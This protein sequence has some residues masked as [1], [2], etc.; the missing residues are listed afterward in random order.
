MEAEKVF[1]DYLKQYDWNDNK[2]HLKIVHTFGVVKAA[3]KIAEGIRM[4]EEDRKLAELIALLHDIGRFEQLKRYHTFDDSV[5]P[6]AQ[7]SI[8]ILFREGMIRKFIPDRSLDSVIYNAIRLHG[9]YR[10]EDSMYRRYA[11][12]EKKGEGWEERL[13]RETDPEVLKRMILH[14]KLIR[15]A[16]KVDNFRVKSEEAVET[17]VDV[18]AKEL[19]REEITPFI[20]DT[21]LKHEPILNADRKTHM[22]MWVSY[23]GY[24]YDLNFSASFQ[25][26]LERD[27]INQIVGRI[28]Y[29]NAD[30]R[31]KMET[32]QKEA[33]AYA[34]SRAEEGGS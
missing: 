16:D 7:C 24:L 14:T 12:E 32:I 6:H 17:M 10:V 18:T 25:Y 3:N 34:K 22:D 30:T 19:G 21:F 31:E 20:Y 11:W 15:D 27:Y 33:S 8:D 26:I 13:P 9:V 5:M 23:L 1:L 4:G 29:S 28:P 2:I